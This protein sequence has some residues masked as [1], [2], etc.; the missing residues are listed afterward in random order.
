MNMEL[1]VERYIRHH[2][3]MDRHG[4]Y[5]VALSGGADSVSLLLVLHR[6]GYHIEACHC[7][8]L[9]RQEESF[10]DEK[11]CSSLCRKLGIPFHLIHFDTHEYAST[12]KVSIEMAARDLRYRY[13][14]QLI[15]DVGANA[16]CVA[17]H[18]DDSI[19]TV[20][21]N[22]I[23]G[24][25]ING[26]TGI[27]PRNGHIVR[28]LLCVNRQ[29][30][31]GYLQNQQQDFVTDSTNLT[32]DVVRNK[33]RLNVLPALRKINPAVN[34]SIAKTAAYLGEAAFVLEKY[35]E[36]LRSESVRTAGKRI[37]IEKQALPQQPSMRHA[38]YT[39]LSPY[40]FSGETID[41]IEKSLPITGKVFSSPTHQLLI[42]REHIVIRPLPGKEETICRIPETGNYI[43]GGNRALRVSVMPKEDSFQP[44]K[45]HHL[46][47]IDADKV[48]FP[49][50]LR[51]AMPGDSFRPFGMRGRKLISDYLTDKK[52][53]L[54]D[55]QDQMVLT[56]RQGIIIWVVGKRM[57]EECRITNHTSNIMKIEDIELKE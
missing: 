36:R 20:L 6:L 38:L 22:L 39:L 28:P 55:K 9:L 7:N 3:L 50:T 27:A 5:V 30:I 49:L 24:T 4:K 25:G 35:A 19:E 1:C 47:T 21:I 23:R 51:H 26:L 17:H 13:F 29:D 45:E 12:H 14:E 54:F 48:A 52:V 46:I 15:Q 34:R 16:V 18:Q 31:L 43:Y 44:S 40:G 2:R 33:I 57:A 32:D 10:R 41:G 42:D 37:M 56:D 11:F 8:F 53:N